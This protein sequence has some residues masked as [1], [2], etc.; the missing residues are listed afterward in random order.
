MNELRGK[1]RSLQVEASILPSQTQT[2]ASCRQWP[3]RCRGQ[4]A[5]P[6]VCVWWKGEI[7]CVRR[8][9]HQK[10]KCSVSL[11]TSF[12]TTSWEEDI[13]PPP[14]PGWARASARFPACQASGLGAKEELRSIQSFEGL[15][16]T[17]AEEGGVCPFPV[18]LLSWDISSHFPLS[19]ATSVSGLRTWSE[20]HRQLSWV[21][22]LQTVG[23]SLIFN[24]RRYYFN[25][26]VK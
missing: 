15:D 19:S 4:E 18:S 7:R 6:Q 3:C 14:L 23:L 24:N 11:R 25:Q 9:T 1:S 2:Q 20:S 13:L 22:N 12:R 26:C 5:P 10:A 8:G 17:R 16:R 21:C